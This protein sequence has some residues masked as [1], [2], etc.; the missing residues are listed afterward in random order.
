MYN[1]YKVHLD[2]Y[3]ATI[4][5][6]KHT[7]HRINKVLLQ[8]SKK[9]TSDEAIYKSGTALV[10][11][12]WTGPTNNGWKIY[13]HTKSIK[14]TSKE[15]YPD[16]INRILSREFAIGIA[17]SY[18]A[19]ETLLKNLIWVK[20]ELNQNFR[21]SLPRLHKDMPYTRENLKGGLSLLELIKKASGDRFNKY[22]KVN[23]H[24]FRFTEIFK[25]L[26]E[27]R[28]SITH[29]QGKFKITQEFNDKYYK[30]L[31]NHFL[32]TTEIEQEII[33]LKFDYG[34][35]DKLIIH[36]AEFGYQMFKILSQEDNFDWAL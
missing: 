31:L 24:N 18:E 33:I 4:T 27:I 2:A 8:D 32:P 6:L 13:Y 22:S 20:I 25:F 19:L 23:N 36:I 9:Y 10:I 26:S 5:D 15:N 14:I 3:F 11:G 21:S 34:I 7:L 16:E 1:P 28:H 17:Q 30:A 35:F 29:S 12:D